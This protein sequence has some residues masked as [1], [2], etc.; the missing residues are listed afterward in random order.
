LEQFGILSGLLC[1]V[2]KTTLL[3][4]GQNLHIDNRI[5]DLGFVIVEKVT[6][7]GLE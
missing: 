5:R 7:L 3:P 6:I 2:D 1:N 4:I